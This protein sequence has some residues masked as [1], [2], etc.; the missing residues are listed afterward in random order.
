MAMTSCFYVFVRPIPEEGQP[1]LPK[2]GFGWI[3]RQVK[4]KE[5][6]AYGQQCT[7][8]S[9][10][11]RDTFF[12][13]MWNAGMAMAILTVIVGMIVMFLVMCTCCVAYK[14][15]MFDGLFWTCMF[16]F[17]AQCL[18]FLTWGSELCN[19]YEC[20]WSSGTGLNLTALMMWVWAANMVKSFPEVL[21]PRKRRRR[22]RRHDDEG[23][24]D[25]EYGDVYLSNRNMNR[26]PDNIDGNASNNYDYDNGQYQDDDGGGWD[27]DAD[28]Y[29]DG[30]YDDDGNWVANES[31]YSG[32]DDIDGREG[33]SQYQ[34]E[35][36]V[37]YDSGSGYNYYDNE[38]D[39]SNW[40]GGTDSEYTYNTD[41]DNDTG[42]GNDND[43]DN[44]DDN[45]NDNDNTDGEQG[46]TATTKKVKT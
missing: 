18:T 28:D 42:H 4:V 12:D 11:E 17:A 43:N 3:S 41:N 24:D 23:Y 21:Q 39:D 8:Y 9:S 27:T 46:A 20:T 25:D 5:P 34:D 15:P 22:N 7:W 26:N 37:E 40:A 38:G 10:E 44:D 13:S 6:P 36:N 16:C 19:E 31:S 32:H 45:D 14:M 33:D 29:G 30:Y 2:E 35:Y 1:E